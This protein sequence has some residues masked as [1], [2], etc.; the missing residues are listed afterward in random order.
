MNST[1]K[2][3]HNPTRRPR[4][5]EQTPGTTRTT[6]KRRLT[7]SAGIHNDGIAN[8]TSKIQKKG[9]DTQQRGRIRVPPHLRLHMPHA[10]PKS[11]TATERREQALELTKQGASLRQIARVIGVSHK[12]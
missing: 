5:D 10:H 11:L 4:H 12:R 9:P 3:S 7:E 2:T 1:T 6:K 8:R